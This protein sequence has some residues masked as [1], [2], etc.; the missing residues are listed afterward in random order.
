MRVACAGEICTGSF[1]LHRNSH[2]MD[3]V[4][5]ERPKNMRAKNF[6]CFRMSKDFRKA[7]SFMVTARA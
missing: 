7:F 5:C 2:F 4:T 3:E 1:K 6:I